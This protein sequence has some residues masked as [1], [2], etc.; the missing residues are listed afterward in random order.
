M[1]NLGKLKKAWHWISRYRL[2]TQQTSSADMATIM[3]MMDTVIALQ[4]KTTYS[5][6]YED[7]GKMFARQSGDLTRSAEAEGTS[8]ADRAALLHMSGVLLQKAKELKFEGAK[9]ANAGKDES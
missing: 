1:V 8:R 3:A 4:V 9:N 5:L 7:V 2:S 6:T